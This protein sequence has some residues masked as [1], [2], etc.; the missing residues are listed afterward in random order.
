M[1]W[2]CIDSKWRFPIILIPLYINLK[3]IFISLEW[4]FGENPRVLCFVFELFETIRRNRACGCLY[5]IWLQLTSYLSYDFPINN[6]W[7]VRCCEVDVNSTRN[8]LL[9][10]FIP[11][12]NFS[13][14]WRPLPVKSSNFDL[15]SAIMAIEQR[16]F[17]SMPHLLWHG[18]FF[19]NFHHRGP[20]TLTPTC[21]AER[22]AV[23]LSLPVFTT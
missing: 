20:V 5:L 22:L 8:C 9:R 13:L 10:F 1:A 2:K 19:Y 6:A 3:L 15:C 11:I 7:F 14:E 4:T 16:G 12:E 21:I 17:F 18:A 23:E